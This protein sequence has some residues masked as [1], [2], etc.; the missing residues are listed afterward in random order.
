MRVKEKRQLAG[1]AGKMLYLEALQL[2]LRRQVL[3]LVQEQGHK[4]ELETVVRDLWDLRTRGATAL[5]HSSSA[6]GDGPLEVFSSQASSE[7]PTITSS[8]RSKAQ[9]WSPERGLDWPLPKLSDTLGLCYIGCCLLRVPTRLGELI[10]WVHAGSLPYNRVVSMEDAVLV[11]HECLI[12]YTCSFMS[13]LRKCR[14]ECHPTIQ[15]S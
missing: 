14:T 11:A 13:C 6:T 10:K 3:W 4:E 8:S 1:H 15:R 12:D 7:S 5:G 9:S 2:L